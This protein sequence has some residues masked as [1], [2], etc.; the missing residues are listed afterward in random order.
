MVVRRDRTTK[1]TAEGPYA[2]V[3]GGGGGGGGV[4]GVG[5]GGGEVIIVVVVVD[6]V[7]RFP[8]N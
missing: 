6:V 5:G 2:D 7:R 4:G 1:G 3:E 8:Q